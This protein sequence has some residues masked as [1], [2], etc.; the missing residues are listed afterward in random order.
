MSVAEKLERL[1]RFLPGVGGYLDRDTARETDKTLRMRLVVDLKQLKLDLEEEKRYFMELSDIT[2]LAKLDRLTSKL[3]KLSNLVKYA[4]RGY[5]GFFDTYKHDQQTLN[6]LYSFDLGLFEDVS[7]MKV[8]VNKVHDA[9]S[10]IGLFKEA[11]ATMDHL[12]DQFER[13]FAKRSDI[14]TRQGA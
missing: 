7:S 4:S 9:R 11:A 8:Q 13:K 2:P 14:L 5:R 3:D 1:A 6:Q 12:L 10:D